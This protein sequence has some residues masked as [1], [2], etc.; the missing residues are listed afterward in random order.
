MPGSSTLQH[1]VAVF[2]FT[3]LVS[4]LNAQDSDQYAKDFYKLKENFDHL[5]SADYILWNGRR[6][7]R[8]YYNSIGHPFFNSENFREG[9]LRI[10]G[11]P[12]EKVLI[13]YD[14]SIQQVILQQTGNSGSNDQIMLTRELVD[15][16]NLDGKLFRQMSFPETGTRFFQIIRTGEIS[17]YLAWEKEMSITGTP[18]TPY[19][20]ASQSRDAYLLVSGQLKSFKSLASFIK[21]LGKE[22]NKEIRR[23][24]RQHRIRLRS[25]SDEDLK[26]LIDYCISLTNYK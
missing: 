10:N 4:Q 14:I 5:S 25:A 9:S 13:N 23:Y 6:Y 18:K 11:V 20:F 26:Q 21:I 17:C 8:F 19:T 2:L 1:C 22:N 24:R 12:Y 16:F 15:E 7:Q 3:I